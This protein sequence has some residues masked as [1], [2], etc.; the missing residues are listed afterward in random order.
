VPVVVKIT[1]DAKDVHDAI[2]AVRTNA[3]RGVDVP[4]TSG[5]SS[6]AGAAGGAAVSP[7]AVG[8]LAGAELSPVWRNW[9]QLPAGVT[10]SGVDRAMAFQ[11]M[12]GMTGGFPS[13]A[14]TILQTST[15]PVPPAIN[16]AAPNVATFA[17]YASNA[18]WN[19]VQQLGQPG[20][21][22]QQPP[23][24]QR[25]RNPQPQPLPPPP[26]N[27]N[28]QPWWARGSG[29]L[30]NVPSVLGY[31]TAINFAAHAIAEER[32]Y[33]MAMTLAGNDQRGQLEATL[34]F[35]TSLMNSTG[36]VGRIMGYA[37]DPSGNIE[38][39]IRSQLA[40]ANGQDARGRSA[41]GNARD[42]RNI[43]DRADVAA[44]INPFDR[45]ML[46]IRRERETAGFDLVNR[47]RDYERSQDEEI[48]NIV[49]AELTADRSG[50]VARA[51]QL[52]PPGSDP[53][54]W[55]SAMEQAEGEIASQKVTALR[56]ERY[57]AAERTTF[58]PMRRAQARLF[59]SQEKEAS[60]EEWY[61]IDDIHTGAKRETAIA[62]DIAAGRGDS[63][64]LK[65]ID[66]AGHQELIDAMRR[67]EDPFTVAAIAG[68]AATRS[69]AARSAIAR[70]RGFNAEDSQ[71]RA[72]VVRDLI[73]RNPL[74]AA[75]REIEHERGTR[76]RD[77]D[78]T[79]E[80]LAGIHSE[81]NAKLTKA[82]QDA[83][84]EKRYRAAELNADREGL[85][86]AAENR[87][88]AGRSRTSALSA[89]NRAVQLREQ[90]NDPAAA[91]LL[92]G[93]EILEQK[94]MRK[95]VFEGFEAK[96][97]DISTTALNGPR[98]GESSEKYLADIAANIRRLVAAQG[99]N[100]GGGAFTTD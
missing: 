32:D 93:N 60:R 99:A 3:A 18:Y 57:G 1:G 89:I 34:Q 55:N 6:R 31:G 63:A 74:G 8:M 41:I 64:R 52:A 59:E 9:S 5:G 4:V 7:S 76:L 68:T 67:N 53:D 90:A 77:G 100:G 65:S 92:L 78:L 22:V 94:A 58:G 98:S 42:A 49:T 48:K 43:I 75:E 26:P 72:D 27:P 84:D 71:S 83:G 80:E 79:F 47:Q 28:P 2:E 12:G 87:P 21:G 86:L 54:A 15:T 30:R 24:G 38:A 69:Q 33:N 97:V 29:F 95:A 25:P 96:E 10:G 16:P 56:R 45:K 66:F 11:R 46:Q 88:M 40:A 23:P 85:L 35:R 50:I 51:K 62:E 36:F 73:G 91:N 70:Q 17:P 44:T 13:P 39:G 20:A 61:R 81:A 19:A 37:Q 14:G 82:R